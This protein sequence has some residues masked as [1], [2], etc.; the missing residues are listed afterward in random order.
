MHAKHRSFPRH[1]P[2]DEGPTARDIPFSGEEHRGDLLRQRVQVLVQ[3]LPENSSRY[4]Q[5][6]RRP[7]LRWNRAGSEGAQ[8]L[9]LRSVR[10]NVLFDAHAQ[11]KLR[12]QPR[13]LLDAQLFVPV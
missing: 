6:C 10:K 5:G 11:P 4:R 3:Q 13:G 12:N 8:V 7:G 1:V 9:R 2:S